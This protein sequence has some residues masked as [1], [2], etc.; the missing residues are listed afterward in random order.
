VEEEDGGAPGVG[1][2]WG[3]G[4]KELAV[5]MQAVGGVEEDLLGGDEGGS[6]IVVGNGTGMERGD[7]AVAGDER[8]VE[9]RVR[10]GDEGGDGSI[11]SDLGLGFDARTVGEFYGRGVGPGEVEEPEVAAVLIEGMGIGGVGSGLV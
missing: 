8:R 1:G 3:A 4:E 2:G 10:I 5:E 9:G 6:G 11:G 7:F